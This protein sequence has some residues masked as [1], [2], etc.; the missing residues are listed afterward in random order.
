MLQAGRSILLT[1]PVQHH[2]PVREKGSAA[3]VHPLGAGSVVLPVHIHDAV[4]HGAHGLVHG[5]AYQVVSPGLQQ[6][7]GVLGDAVFH[8]KA[9]GLVI[10]WM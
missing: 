7:E 6:L 1:D 5:V 9:L 3:A 8:L 4:E 10:T 2:M